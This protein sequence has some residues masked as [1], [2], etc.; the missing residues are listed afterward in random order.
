M[1]GLRVLLASSEVAG[2]AKTGGLAD[3]AAAL[4]RA[5]SRLG[6]QVAI[7][8]PLYAAIRRSNIPIERTNV[9]L[10][11]P[12]GPRVLACRLYRSQLANSEVPVYLI[13]HEPYYDRDNPR[14]GRGL[15]QQQSGGN[16][17][18]YAD[19]AERFVFFSRAVMELV[20]HLGF[21]PDV[22]H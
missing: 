3:V 4:P 22:I 21:T 11:V 15:Y 7:A 10:P 17:T 9:V 1:P 2:F 5:L 6:N 19:N 13:E 16:R 8:M 14:E 12:M 20:P 18:D